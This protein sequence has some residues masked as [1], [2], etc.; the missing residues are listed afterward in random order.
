MGYDYKNFNYTNK[1][2]YNYLS[3]SVMVDVTYYNARM[4][5]LKKLKELVIVLSDQIKELQEENKELNDLID[6]TIKNDEQMKS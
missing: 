1:K 6:W 4:A 3:R 2:D 5:E